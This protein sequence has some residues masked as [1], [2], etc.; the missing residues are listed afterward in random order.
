MKCPNCGT[1]S[2]GKFCPNCG[3][4]LV[5]RQPE[6]KA[7]Q[8]GSMKYVM[9]AA[10]ILAVGMIAASLIVVFGL[11][12]NDG[13]IH[14]VPDDSDPKVLSSVP[15]DE[16][17]SEGDAMPTEELVEDEQSFEGDGIPM[18][19]LVEGEQSSD[20]NATDNDD[21]PLSPKAFIELE[22]AIGPILPD[23]HA[24]N[25]SPYGVID[26]NNYEILDES[27]MYWMI[28]FNWKIGDTS[29]YSDEAWSYIDYVPAY[30]VNKL[31]GNIR[32]H[33]GVQDS[34][35]GMIE[36]ALDGKLD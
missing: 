24:A 21:L 20:E 36:D 13:S 26:D 23:V 7:K 10:T 18:K 31:T 2:S 34:W 5:E 11:H 15:S 12:I 28:G 16:Q 6:Q 35:D 22:D 8:A 33:G 1:D 19:E 4:S 25:D 29:N 17:S 30:L 14:P 9:I 32:W 3:S 27:D